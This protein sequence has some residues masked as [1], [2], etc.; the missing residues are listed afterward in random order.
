MSRKKGLAVIT[1]V[2]II[3]GIVTYLHWINDVYP[4]DVAIGELTRAKSCSYASRMRAYVRKALGLLNKYEG[5]PAWIFP[6]SET[7][8]SAIKY[9]LRYLENRLRQLT[10]LRLSGKMVDYNQGLNDARLSIDV[11]IG[12]LTKA[13][14]WVLFN[15]LYTAF[16]II[17]IT[18]II[19][20]IVLMVR[21]RPKV[22][23]IME[24]R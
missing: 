22:T 3:L 19:A 23:H 1:L 21:R 18:I 16:L 17:C 12:A 5:N 13:K 9:D 11:I 8:F 2:L 7:R 20:V 10:I 6:T 14:Y 15:P 24:T 4:I